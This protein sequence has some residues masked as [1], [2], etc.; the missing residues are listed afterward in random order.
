MIRKILKGVA[1]LYQ[2]K[3]KSGRQNYGTKLRRTG[4]ESKT[5]TASFTPLTSA[6]Q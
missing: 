2:C 5:I 6:A 4:I 1:K 3:V